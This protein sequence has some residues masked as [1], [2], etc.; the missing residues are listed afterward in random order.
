M[1]QR[2][3]RLSRFSQTP[4]EFLLTL[5]VSQSRIADSLNRAGQLIVEGRPDSLYYQMI[6]ARVQLFYEDSPG[7][8]AQR[9]RALLDEH[10]GE[11]AAA[12]YGLALALIRSG[13][14]DSAEQELEPLLAEYPDNI[15]VQL[16]QVELD[17]SRNRLDQ[18]LT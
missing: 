4:P 6:R 10:D 2:L 9:F 8:A 3:A 16:A 11:H 7:L 15:A 17:S 12:R 13:Q 5:P 14:Q 1:F 18:A